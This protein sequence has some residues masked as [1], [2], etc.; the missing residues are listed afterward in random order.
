M[1]SF[2]KSPE[3]S[4]Y[5]SVG[6]PP[7]EG[8][9]DDDAFLKEFLSEEDEEVSQYRTGKDYLFGG[10]KFQAFQEFLDFHSSLSEDKLDIKVDKSQQSMLP[11]TRASNVVSL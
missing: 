4:T 8:E 5:T 6:L 1:E 10:Q 3:E 7:G 2:S 9:V 11:S